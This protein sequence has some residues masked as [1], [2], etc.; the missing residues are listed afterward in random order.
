MA[1]IGIVTVLYNSEKVLD[2]FFE[3]LESQTIKDIILYVVDNASSDGGLKKVQQLSKNISFKCKII[4]ESQNGGIAKGN[5]IGIREALRDGCQYILL[6][7]N[8]IVLND[9]YTLEKLLKR[10]EITNADIITPKIRKYSNPDEIWAA[11]GRFRFF[12]TKTQHIGANTKDTDKFNSE[13]E[14]D[15]TPTCFVLIR[16]DV[17]DKVGLMDER[18]FVYFDDTDFIH[19]VKRSGHTIKYTPCTSILHNESSSTG[20][21]SYFKIYQLSKNQLIYT[22]KNFSKSIYFLLLLRNWVIHYTYHRIKFNKNQLEAEYTGLID[23]MK[24]QIN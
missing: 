13:R 15:Y 19:R 21:M 8:D 6:S 12:G 24:I 11:G 14:I 9:S 16:R 5:N 4:P 20:K 10:I 1:K 18:F 3:S 17:F 23:G 2:E 7:N 22:K